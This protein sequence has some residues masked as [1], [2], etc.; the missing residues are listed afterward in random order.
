MNPPSSPHMPSPRRPARLVSAIWRARAVI[1]VGLTAATYAAMPAGAQAAS[2]P[3]ASTLAASSVAYSSVTLNGSVNPRGQATNYVFQYG[4]THN[5]GSETPLAPAG[6]GNGAGK[7]S[8]TITGLAP[9]TTYHYRILAANASGATAGAERTFTTPRVPLSL[10]IAGAPNPV[11]F[12]S[13]L[14]VEGTLSGTGS[15]NHEVELQANAF[16]Y[17][18]GFQVIGN[19][20]L[21]SSTG[22]FSFPYLGLTQNAQL[23][24]VTI[25]KPEISSPIVLEG[26][27]VRVS[28][29]VRSTKRRGYARLYGTVTPAEVGALVGFQLLRPGKS[30]NKGGTVVKAATSA[31][32]STFSRVVRVQHGLYKALVQVTDGA[33]VSAYSNPVLIG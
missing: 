30:A 27:A 14:L 11:R 4:T 7:V 6:S 24:V 17:T 20:E 22:T 9:L 25:G 5:Y 13:P 23:R 19:P 29:H 16:P 10:A 31:D 28:F 1:A 32:Y 21:T 18:A 3:G 15:A 26:V 2:T 8:Q 12:G 33:H